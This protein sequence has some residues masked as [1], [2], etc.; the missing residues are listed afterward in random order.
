MDKTEVLAQ[1]KEARELGMTN[2]AV[3]LE[4]YTNGVITFNELKSLLIMEYA[5]ERSRI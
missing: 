5:M 1:A 2:C 3:I 4:N